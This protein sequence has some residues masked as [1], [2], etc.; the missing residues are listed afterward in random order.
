MITASSAARSA[1]LPTP[2]NGTIQCPHCGTAFELSEAVRHAVEADLRGE[3]EARFRAEMSNSVAKVRRDADAEVR[4]LGMELE[5]VRKKAGDAAANEAKLLKKERELDE[6]AR[7][8]DLSLERRLA[9]E[10]KRIHDEARRAADQRLKFAVAEEA[11]RKERELVEV[12]AQLKD[13]KRLEAELVD[14][15]RAVAERERSVGAELERRLAEESK[16]IAEESRRAAEERMSAQLAAE[17]ERRT[18]EAA[19]AQRLLAEAR[20][21]ELQLVQQ[22]RLDAEKAR[23]AGLE[24]ERKLTAEM[25]RVRAELEARAA[26]RVSFEIEQARL[27]EQDQKQHIERLTQKIEE[28]RLR[29]LQRSQ[30]AVGEAQEVLLKYELERAFGHDEVEDVAKGAHG[31]DLLQRVVADDGRACGTIVWESKRTRTWSDDWL[32]KLRDDQRASGAELA[33]IVSQAL[34][35][36]VHRADLRDGVWICEWSFAVPLATALRQGMI[37]A[38][39]V[40]RSVEG[41]GDKMALVYD[42]LTG[43][44]FRNRVSGMLEAFKE[45]QDGLAAEQR[46]MRTQW[47]RRERQHERALTNIAAFYGDLQGLAG[48]SL[49]DLDLLSLEPGRALTSGTADEEPA[50]C[51]DVGDGE[52]DARLVQLLRDLLP[53][54]GASIG[55]GSLRARFVDQALLMLGLTVGEA[56]YDRCRAVLLAAG[57]ARRGKGR[58]GSIARAEAP[59][60]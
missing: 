38:A 57:E 5:A 13:A 40:R 23:Q 54:D 25:Q 10:S 27:R 45:M 50:D 56:E 1:T 3:L 60:A 24:A 15:Q 43:T 2:N 12:R 20:D 44:E 46:A 58:G 42:Y 49:A 52:V 30:E 59:H 22:H 6:R 11:E 55:N 53:K 47:K 9:D 7:E 48:K 8:L 35:P 21:R 16:R 39:A 18:A 36:G 34:P 17:S 41:R 4:K 26:Q 19:E 37:Q 51:D 32:A 33:I 29:A 31:A 14:R 28:L